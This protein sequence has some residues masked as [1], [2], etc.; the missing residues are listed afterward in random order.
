MMRNCD[1]RFPFPHP[2]SPQRTLTHS[3]VLNDIMLRFR[4]PFLQVLLHPS[5]HPHLELLQPKHIGSFISP[6]SPHPNA[7][8]FQS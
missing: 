8:K 3:C 2:L 1:D 7:L 6:V 5:G 4:Q